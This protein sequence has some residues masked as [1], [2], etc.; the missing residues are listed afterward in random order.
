MGQWTTVWIPFVFIAKLFLFQH[1]ESA[2][3]ESELFPYDRGDYHKLIFKDDEF[4]QVNW[5]IG[6]NFFNTTFHSTF[7]SGNGQISFE[8]GIAK[9]APSCNSSNTP[10]IMAY[11][12]DSISDS[13]SQVLYQE[14]RDPTLLQKAGTDIFLAFPEMKGISLSWMFL[15]T[16]KNMAFFGADPKCN[17]LSKRNTYQL[18]LTTDGYYTFALMY[19]NRID[20]T[21]GAHSFTG[22]DPC[23]GLSDIRGKPARVGFDFGDGKTLYTVADSCTNSILNISQTSN[24]NQPG[25]WAFQ[26]ESNLGTSSCDDFEF[27]K[28]KMLKLSPNVVSFAGLQPLKIE[29]PCLKR[30]A[31]A[32]CIF[33]DVVNKTRTKRFVNGVISQDYISISCPLPLFHEVGRKKVDLKI[34]YPS[35]SRSRKGQD[36]QVYTGYIYALDDASWSEHLDFEL[37]KKVNSENQFILIAYWNPDYF[38]DE[39]NIIPSLVDIILNIHDGNGW[40][41]VGVVERNISNNGYFQGTIDQK[42]FEDW[43][44]RG[45]LDMTFLIMS[46]ST[47]NDI[48]RKQLGSKLLPGFMSIYEM[49]PPQ[50]HPNCQTITLPTVNTTACPPTLEHANI[51]ANFEDDPDHK[52]TPEIQFSKRQSVYISERGNPKCKYDQGGNLIMIPIGRGDTADQNN[53]SDVPLY[54][55]N[56]AVPNAICDRSTTTNEAISYPT[57][58]D[59]SNYSSRKFARATGDPHISTFDGFAYTFNGV[60]EFWLVK[61]I[62]PEKGIEFKMQTRMEQCVSASSSLEELKPLKA[63]VITSVVMEETRNGEKVKVQVTSARRKILVVVDEIPVDIDSKEITKDFTLKFKSCSI[64]IKKP[65]LGVQNE[66]VIVTFSSSFSFQ[67]STVGPTEV[68]LNLIGSVNSNLMHLIEGAF[69]IS[70]GAAAIDEYEDAKE[71][72]MSDEFTIR[73][74]E[75]VHSYIALKWMIRQQNESIFNYRPGESLITFFNPDFSPHFEI[76][77]ESVPQNVTN[78]CEQNEE[79][80]FDYVTTGS[81]VL[82]KATLES[83]REYERLVK[84]AEKEVKLCPPLENPEGCQLFNLNNAIAGVGKADLRCAE[85]LSLNCSCVDSKEEKSKPKWMCGTEQD[86]QIEDIKNPVLRCAEPPTLANV[87]LIFDGDNNALGSTVDVKCDNEDGKEYTVFWGEQK[88]NGPDGICPESEPCPNQTFTCVEKEV[89]TENGTILIHPVWSGYGGKNLEHVRCL[90]LE[91]VESMRNIEV[92]STDD[93]VG[94]ESTFCYNTRVTG[95]LISKSSKLVG[96]HVVPYF[97]FIFTFNFLIL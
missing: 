26:I 23:K 37:K 61:Y 74:N 6:F 34:S 67:F 97:I 86:N 41:E 75:E 70:R 69:K 84:L 58:N 83:I 36:Q 22:G 80:I 8:R 94:S 78:L 47:G 64:T 27:T 43:G 93:S 73:T 13:K 82:A 72:E 12:S 68:A 81:T 51:D 59:G 49:F 39:D 33:H 31:K 55:L 66:T 28:N 77:F 79:C 85:N 88:F 76:D 32:K 95:E 53:P 5:S 65:L 91:Q 90:R 21:T 40:S 11:W 92:N 2:V 9:F 1:C 96:V 7:L 62:D 15:V 48:L 35:T 20:W 63:S 60:G 71:Y 3:S 89:T 19:Y 16:W 46:P 56:D 87:Q 10:M 24:F 4:L 54:F 57:N 42:V 17:G 25:K 52:A 18:V 29:G 44:N 45:K 38:R 14:T 50:F 30:R